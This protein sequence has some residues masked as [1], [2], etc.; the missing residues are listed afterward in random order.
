MRVALAPCAFASLNKRR[1][2][3]EG[4]ARLVAQRWSV[5]SSQE[6]GEVEAARELRGQLFTDLDRLAFALEMEAAQHLDQGEAS[7][8]ERCQHQ[9]LGVRL[10]QRLVAGV[11]ADEV[12]VRIHRWADE[13]DR[14][15]T[16]G[17]R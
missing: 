13:Y 1:T 8:A 10:A 5:T 3:G 4:S 15:L 14:R 7:R 17:A 6:A 16:A 11:W 2:A 9:R 12:N